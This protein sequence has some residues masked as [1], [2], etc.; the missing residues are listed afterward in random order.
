M[1][2][3]PASVTGN[4]LRPVHPACPAMRFECTVPVSGSR[5]IATIHGDHNGDTPADNTMVIDLIC[6]DC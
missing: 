6:T 3:H 2:F 1:T 5:A 4:P